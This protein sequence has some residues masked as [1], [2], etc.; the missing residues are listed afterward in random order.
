MTQ[1]DPNV[2]P[3]LEAFS[4][5]LDAYRPSPNQE[6]RPAGPPWLI[7]LH[8]TAMTTAD[9]AAARL[10][11]PSAKVSAH[12]LIA[13]DGRIIGLVDERARAW[14]AGVA[15]WRGVAD[16]NAASIGVELAHPGDAADVPPFRAP[17]MDALERLLDAA[18][19]RWRIGADGVLGHSDV[20]PGRKIDPG[21]RFDWARLARAGRAVHPSPGDAAVA[22]RRAAALAADAWSEAY[23]R[24]LSA[25]GFGDWPMPAR[26]D[27]VRRRF[28]GA[29]I[30][31]ADPAPTRA[32]LTAAFAAERAFARARGERDPA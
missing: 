7:V 16:V 29:P 3:P 30:A 11:D 9:A 15:E 32:D 18:M 12:Y 2:A 6:P 23:A 31:S 26:F 22:A 19:A 25:I 4:V 20:A 1:D 13:E 27:A 28:G 10:S 14:H 17:Q 21:P 24:S 8:Y 5:E